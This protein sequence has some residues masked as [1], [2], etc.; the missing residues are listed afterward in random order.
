MEIKTFDTILTEICDY[1]DILIAPKTIARTNTNI[2]YLILKGISK[3]WEVINN[4]C[5]VL[6]NKFDPLNCSDEDLVSVA[7]LVGTQRRTGAVTG[8]SISVYNSKNLPL[9]LL[10]GTYK[11]ILSEDVS[12]SFTLDTNLLINTESSVSF[13]ALSDK[14][15][16]YP[17]TQQ[18]KIQVVSEDVDIPSEF[19]F[20]CTDNLP[21]L[22]HY[23]ESTLEFR[24]RINTDTER[25]D[26]INELKEKLLSLPYVYDCTLTFNQTES[27]ISVGNFSVKPY[28]LLI[29]ISTAK[30]TNEIADIIAKNAIYPTVKVE[31][32]S[33][34]VEY[35]NEVFASGRYK[36]YLNDFVKKSFSINLNVLIDSVHNSSNIVRSKIES[37]LMNAFNS[38]VYRAT[39]T[40]EDVFDEISKLELAGV[41]VL[42]V[43]FEV[44][45]STLN[46]VDFNKTE[47]PNL[48]NVGG[49]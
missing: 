14:I 25:Q 12:F 42:G 9:E 30:Y 16:V 13:I 34:E 17:V 10:Q 24:Q 32:E 7:K 11:Y 22:G 39:I 2:I 3:G 41:K 28:H 48:I 33:H 44:D 5:V 6:N 46:Y 43:T 20:S 37:S 45:S 26:I 15:G 18:S 8:L 21:L 1:F 27:D 19:I 38:N 35:I 23:P 36:V 31:G 29:V 49:I 4:V 40:A 47:L